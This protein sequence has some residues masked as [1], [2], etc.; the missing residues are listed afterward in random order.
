MMRIIGIMLAEI[1]LLFGMACAFKDSACMPD[2]GNS[3]QV[4]YARPFEPRT[5]PAFLVLPPGA[6]EPT[7]WLRDWC[8]AARDGYTAHMD[9]YDD[10]FKRAWAADH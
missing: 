5:R 7:G 3:G 4:N 1:A 6:V 2:S 8:V 10:E 9:Q